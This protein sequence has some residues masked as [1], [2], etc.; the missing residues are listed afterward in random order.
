MANN[1]FPGLF[2]TGMVQGRQVTCVEDAK[3]ALKTNGST[4]RT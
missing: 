4:I 2:W 1:F 3:K